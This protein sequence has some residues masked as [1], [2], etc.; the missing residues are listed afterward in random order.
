M[1]CQHATC[2][3]SAVVWKYGMAQHYENQHPDDDV[4]AIYTV[5]EAEE[6]KLIRLL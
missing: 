2:N 1:R 4:P 3:N 6:K 5:S